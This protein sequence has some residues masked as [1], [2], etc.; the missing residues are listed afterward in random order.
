MKEG[1]LN[2]DGLSADDLKGLLLM[3]DLVG[4]CRDYESLSPAVVISSLCSIICTVSAS[5]C[6]DMDRDEQIGFISNI[7]EGIK[8]ATLIQIELINKM[9]ATE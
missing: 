9:E 4:V 2:F 7:A 3:K 6:Y 8:K 5:S 1:S